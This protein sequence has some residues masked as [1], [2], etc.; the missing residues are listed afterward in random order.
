MKRTLVL[1]GV[2]ISVVVLG[3]LT[4]IATNLLPEGY[5]PPPW[6]VWT[7]LIVVA[8]SF[9]AFSFWQDADARQSRRATDQSAD[10]KTLRRRYLQHLI[11][12]YQHLEFKGI[13]QFEKLPLRMSLE[14]VYVN[15]WAQ[16][17][18]PT[19]ETL[20][21][22][23]RLAGRKIAAGKEMLLDDELELMV[24]RARPVQVEATLAEHPALVILGD[25][26]SGK[27]TLLKHLA[28]AAARNFDKEK[29]LPI[30]LPLAA[31]AHALQANPQLSLRDFL[32]EFYKGMQEFPENPAALFYNALAS[33]NALI[34]LDGLDEVHDPNER[35]RV[36]YHVKNFYLNHRGNITDRSLRV[37]GQSNCFVITSRIVGYREAPLDADGVF[38]L[39]LL[40]FSQV[41][42]GQFAK[43]WCLTYEIAQS[44]DT[45]K[46][47]R[48]AEGE[49]S[50]LLKAIL[51][52]PGVEKLAANP[53]LLTI[54][55]L[56]HR[57]GTELPNRRAELYEL[58][59]TTLIKTW[60]RARSLAGMSVG[61][62]DDKETVKILAPLAYWMHANRPSGTARRAEL[63]REIARH[64][65]ERR[66]LALEDAEREATRFL[67]DVRQYSG[68][69]AERGPD[70][71]GFVH[72]TFEEY[73]AA[74]HIVF[75]GQVNEQKSL[76]LLRKHAYDPAW[77][78][79]ILLALGYLGLIANEE[80]KTAL[81][82]RGLLNDQPPADHLGEN[83]ELAGSALKDIGRVSV[84]E[85]CW[86]E[87]IDRLLSTMTNPAPTIIVRARCGDVLGELGDPRLEKMEWCEVPE[88]EFLMGCTEEEAELI[89]EEMREFYLAQSWRYSIEEVTKRKR[90]SLPQ[91]SVFLPKFYICKF[92]TTNQEFR[93]FGGSE[94]YQ[95]VRWWNLAGLDWLGRSV[96]VEEKMNLDKW[97]RR[98]GRTEPA[99]WNDSKYGIPNRPVV[100]VTWFE[101]IAYSA[102]L[103]EQLQSAGKLPAGYL[104]RLPTEAEWEKAAR[105][106]DGRYWPWGNQWLDGYANTHATH[107]FTTCSVGLFSI[108]RAPFGALDITGNVRE[109]CQSLLA[110]YPY[111]PKDGRETI[112]ANGERV[113]RSSSWY[114]G[115]YAARCAFRQ[116]Y[117]PD[118][119]H[120]GL[121]F[122]VVIGP[123]LD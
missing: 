101:A 123:K 120:S 118:K 25:P 54:L 48:D 65:T 111:D 122:R 19:G 70:A 73:L 31:Y 33:G 41:Q 5:L 24:E 49:K 112:D 38:H 58:Y 56:I 106:T 40:D 6:I 28:L 10:L 93:A 108:D 77:R 81:F 26:G 102:W 96:D 82:V 75:Q 46:A 66:K 13:V 20:K 2:A 11:D 78:E 92:P 88:G 69:L 29:R 60:N 114:R 35:N 55:A 59:L 104:V 119:Y 16:P 89:L 45:P 71:Y 39:T 52:N 7:A 14:K 103:N 12:A 44:G 64:F 63:E 83:V 100:G 17:E 37:T 30:L 109:W 95:E 74:R 76:E 99:Y 107:L 68:L 57:Q 116:S 47:A 34:L 62:M 8:L 22:E 98:D 51:N 91:H 36:V 4:N 115:K 15:L 3:I 97:Q 90:E 53:L 18:L 84:G 32:P 79:V 1:T 87:V 105:G 43:N 42:I 85:D 50:K 61:S 23:L 27:S 80:E 21:E 94:G 9:I 110:H 72:L 86:K 67:D 113:I 121:G 117:P